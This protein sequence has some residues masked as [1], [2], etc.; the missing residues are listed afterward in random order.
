MALATASAEKEVLLREI[1]HRVKNN[2]QQVLSLLGFQPI[3]DETKRVLEGRVAAMVAVHEHIYQNDEFDTIDAREYIGFLVRQTVEGISN[4]AKVSLAVDGDP[5]L[6]SP[7]LAMPLG[8]MVSE[9]V[10]NSIKYGFS[11]GR[12]GEIAVSLTRLDDCR[13]RLVIRDNGV[14]FDPED[15][16]TGMGSRLIRSF[17]RQMNGEATLSSTDGVEFCCEFSLQ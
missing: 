9:V 15:G 6:I 10:T 17:A 3:P 4:G 7:D 1:H 12:E 11:D 13:A 8:Q 16:N 2:L 14:G 5:I